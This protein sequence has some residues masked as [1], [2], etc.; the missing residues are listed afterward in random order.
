MDVDMDDAAACQPSPV[1]TKIETDGKI[2][3]KI[4]FGA[5]SRPESRDPPQ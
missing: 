1:E 2:K 4:R 3:L 5:F